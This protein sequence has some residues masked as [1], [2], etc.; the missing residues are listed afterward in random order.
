MREIVKGMLNSPICP[1]ITPYLYL[2][3]SNTSL[4]PTTQSTPPTIPYLQLPLIYNSLLSSSLSNF[5]CTPHIS[6]TLSLILKDIFFLSFFL[7]FFFWGGTFFSSFSTFYFFFIFFFYINLPE[8]PTPPHLQPLVLNLLSFLF[9]L[10]GFFFSFLPSQPFFIFILSFTSSRCLFF[11]F[12][13]LLYLPFQT[14][15][16]TQKLI[17]TDTFPAED[18]LWHV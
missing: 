13:S 1:P 15:S 8:S 3:P 7:H 5:N 12:F 2:H 10:G 17:N 11:F 9:F 4:S 14:A 16:L 18:E 6:P